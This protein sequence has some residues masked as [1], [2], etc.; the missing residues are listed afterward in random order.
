MNFQRKLFVEDES[1]EET[2]DKA[3]F[4]S[5]VEW[6][7]KPKRFNTF[8]CAGACIL[9]LYLTG[10]W[11]HRRHS[12]TLIQFLATIFYLRMYFENIV[13]IHFSQKYKWY[14]HIIKVHN[15]LWYTVYLDKGLKLHFWVTV[16]V[17]HSGVL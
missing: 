16:L 17:L 2:V 9:L 7:A 4:V 13:C 15:I 6:L 12:H 8:S 1:K 3:I 14:L 11:N 10:W 5:V